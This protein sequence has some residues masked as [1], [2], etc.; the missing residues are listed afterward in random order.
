MPKMELDDRWKAISSLKEKR[1]IFDEFCRTL[2]EKQRQN[3][4]NAA[5]IAADGFVDLLDAIAEHEVVQ[6]AERKRKKG[7]W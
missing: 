3:K 4:E 7:E 5:R 1:S 6:Q 2:A